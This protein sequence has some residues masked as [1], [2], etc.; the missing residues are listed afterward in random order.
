MPPRRSREKE[1]NEWLSA[2]YSR[3]RY[4][5][6]ILVQPKRPGHAPEAAPLAYGRYGALRDRVPEE[7]MEWD[8]QGPDGDPMEDFRISPPRGSA[9]Q[10]RQQR[11]EEEYM[12][13][14][15]RGVL[16]RAYVEEP[17]RS[18]LDLEEEMHVAAVGTQGG[19]R[20]E[21]RSTSRPAFMVC[22]ATDAAVW[23]DLKD[24]R[25]VVIFPSLAAMK[26][27]SWSNSSMLHQNRLRTYFSA[28]AESMSSVTVI[29]QIVQLL[30]G[31]VEV[32]GFPIVHGA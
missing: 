24:I 26:Y 32:Q 3:R 8:L 4:P 25:P 16:G 1:R 23:Q 2:D 31:A 22:K 15:Y 17:R 27:S 19:R 6:C 21:P 7:D 29:R 9:S 5:R 28:A 12:Q 11:E 10:R 18:R 14:V 20:S 30:Q 13:G